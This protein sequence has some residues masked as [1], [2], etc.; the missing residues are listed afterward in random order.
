MEEDTAVPFPYGYGVKFSPS[1]SLDR[2][3]GLISDWAIE[4][5]FSMSRSHNWTHL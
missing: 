2:T 1:R 3:I 4:I 5:M